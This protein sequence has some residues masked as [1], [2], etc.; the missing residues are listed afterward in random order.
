M[1]FA[2]VTLVAQTRRVACM[3]NECV[4]A[5]FA[6]CAGGIVKF[7]NY[8]SVLHL[9]GTPMDPLAQAVY[10][11]LGRMTFSVFENFLSRPEIWAAP[12]AVPTMIHGLDPFGLAAEGD[13][14]HPMKIGFLLQAP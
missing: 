6:H 9:H 5:R 2:P 1:S 11:L 3:E 14:W 8:S 13:T 4:D 12:Q 10:D 7:V